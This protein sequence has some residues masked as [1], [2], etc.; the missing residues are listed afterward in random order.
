MAKK[1]YLVVAA[2]IDFATT[3]F[4]VLFADIDMNRFFV[5][6]VG[7]AI[8]VALVLWSS[9]KL[10]G[11]YVYMVFVAFGA[12][13]QLIPPIEAWRLLILALLLV[14]IW[15]LWLYALEFRKVRTEAAGSASN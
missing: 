10:I 6:A 15:L 5:L 4:G 12:L 7:A 13:S 8:T 9:R 3:A 14:V 2:V 11:A 1:E